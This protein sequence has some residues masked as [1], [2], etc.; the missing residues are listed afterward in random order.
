[1]ALT[2]FSKVVK[3]C[4]ETAIIDQPRIS[5]QIKKQIMNQTCYELLFLVSKLVSLGAEFWFG[6]PRQLYDYIMEKI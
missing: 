4:L 2:S 5:F 3:F 6:N 1:M